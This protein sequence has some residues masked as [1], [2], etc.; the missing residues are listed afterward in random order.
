MVWK[1]SIHSGLSY[2]TSPLIV[3]STNSSGSPARSAIMGSTHMTSNGLKETSPEQW[4]SGAAPSAASGFTIAL[5]SAIVLG[6]SRPGSIEQRLVV[7]EA[8][9]L[10]APAQGEGEGPRGGL[11]ETCQMEALRHPGEHVGHPRVGAEVRQQAVARPR[12]NEQAVEHHEPDR[13][14]GLQR[15]A[16]EPIP[17]GAE[18]RE[19]PDVPLDAG[20]LRLEVVVDLL[21]RRLG[22]R[23][24]AFEQDRDGT[25]QRRRRRPGA[26]RRARRALERPQAAASAAGRGARGEQRCDHAAGGDDGTELEHVPATVRSRVHGPSLVDG[27]RRARSST[28]RVVDASRAV[29]ATSGPAESEYGSVGQ[30]PLASR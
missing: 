4:T 24:A 7:V 11:A 19:R 15:G 26:T 2:P 17:F 29:I 3:L 27:W 10:D 13:L 9:G 28:M 25:G 8:R 20:V 16:R 22:A 23:I 1:A 18:A 30:I 5:R 6:G 21:Q 14:A 12:P